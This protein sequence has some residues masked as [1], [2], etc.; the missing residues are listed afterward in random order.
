M[1]SRRH[2]TQPTTFGETAIVIVGFGHSDAASRQLAAAF[3]AAYPERIACIWRSHG[4]VP[5]ARNR[6]VRYALGRWPNLEPF[7]FLD[8][9]G[10]LRPHT[11][12]RMYERLARG[13]RIGWVYPALERFGTDYGAWCGLVGRR[14]F[15]DGIFFDES[16]ERGHDREF[17]QRVL[18]SGYRSESAGRC[19][20]LRRTKPSSRSRM[21]RQFGTEPPAAWNN[22]GPPHFDL[23][24]DVVYPI[25]AAGMLRVGIAVPRLALGGVDQCVIQLGRAIRRLVPDVSLDLLITKEG[26][27]CGTDGTAAF[28]D[29]IFLEPG[30]TRPLF[31]GRLA[32][33]TC[34]RLRE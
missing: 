32:T 9:D 31:R 7:L 20:F 17:L 12:E 5:A 15:D 26:V 21:L 23:E 24:R 19:G 18:E 27:E 22:E 25:V 34:R 28:D 6:G 33:G 1:R 4:G 13:E 14:V 8:V 29:V 11:L 16:L 3:A 30:R 10:L 2:R